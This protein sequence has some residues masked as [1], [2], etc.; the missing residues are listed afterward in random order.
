M[1][2][3]DLN[4]SIESTITVARNE[5]KYVAE[6]VT[7]FDE[8]MLPAY[9]YAGAFNQVILNMIINAAHAIADVVNGTEKKGTITIATRQLVDAAEISL[10]DTGCGMTQDVIS[11]IF[12]PF[13]T[14]KP[15]GRGTG[16]GLALSHNVIVD[17][18]KGTIDVESTP[19]VGTKFI[20]RIPI[21][22]R[23]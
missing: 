7:D 4:R 19:G 13:F 16:Q 20:I 3:I 21:E 9:C 1:T 8:H 23:S 18:H 6:V 12:D 15:V 22:R 14:T 10:S 17:K 2:A 5:W 11:R